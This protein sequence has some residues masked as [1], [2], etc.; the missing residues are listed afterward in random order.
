MCI[1]TSVYVHIC[2][3]LWAI[4]KRCSQFAQTFA[5]RHH[6]EESHLQRVLRHLAGHGQPNFRYFQI[7]QWPSCNLVLKG[8]WS[9]SRLIFWKSSIFRRA[10][11]SMAKRLGKI[12]S[13][14][15]WGTYREFINKSA[16]PGTEVRQS[17]GFPS[18]SSGIGRS[19]AFPP[20]LVRCDLLVF[21]LWKITIEIIAK[22]SNQHLLH[23]F[24]NFNGLMELVLNAYVYWGSFNGFVGFC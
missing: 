9:W 12:S 16:R 7:P 10:Y 13:S 17:S 2:H 5:L 11:P 14:T 6:T 23:M 20:F 4:L 19:G 18:I 24:G 8:L 3:I 1:N 15:I 22:S 21:G